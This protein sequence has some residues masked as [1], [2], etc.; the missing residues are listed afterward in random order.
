MNN[1]LSTD[2]GFSI[3]AI[4]ATRKPV[5]YKSETSLDLAMKTADDLYNCYLFFNKNNL[6][7]SG[8]SIIVINQID[9][10]RADAVEIGGFTIPKIDIIYQ[11]GSW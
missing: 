11:C 4:K 9:K 10:A 5:F 6:T 8:I 3:Y 7:Y 2:V 1:S